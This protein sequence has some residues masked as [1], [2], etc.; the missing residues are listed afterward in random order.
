MSTDLNSF[1]ILIPAF[2]PDRVLIDLVQEIQTIG[3]RHILVVDDGS[4]KNEIF[5]Y[6]KS[7][8][9]AAVIAH[10]ANRG[11]GAALKTG[12]R[13]IL[14]NLPDSIQ[15]IITADADGQH[16][17]GDILKLARKAIQAPEKFYL[18]ARRFDRNI[19]LRSKF[20]NR[21]TSIAL[22]K[23]K[24]ISLSDT[25]TG[26]RSYPRKLADVA[27][28]ICG[29]RYEF[30]L[31]SIVT[32][33][34]KG[35]IVDE[36]PIATVYIDGNKSSHFKPLLDSLRIY[37]TF[38]RFFLVAVSSV[39]LDF[40]LFILL[41]AISKD[42]IVSTF[43]AR[44]ISSVYNFLCNKYLVFK[45]FN[46]VKGFF[47]ESTGYFILA[48]IVAMISGVLVRGVYETLGASVILTKIMVD[49]LLFFSNYFLQK[50]LVFRE[51]VKFRVKG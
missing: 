25:Q 20:G 34:E 39:V 32:A 13:H 22:E 15:S 9:G 10:E 40:L 41:Y 29:E 26:L 45:S 48:A 18:G 4:E 17:P 27:G 35:F 33:Q 28:S 14:E 43:S 23:A 44:S 30:E 42:I 21:L 24:K 50:N 2:N 51:D 37:A 5:S 8:M 16:L 46:G 12:F 38:S 19:P 36:V 3:F 47:S 1:A 6:L 49:A 31:N 7:S 11:K